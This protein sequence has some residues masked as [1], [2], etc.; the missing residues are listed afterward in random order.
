[1]FNNIFTY[2]NIS[3]FFEYFIFWYALTIMSFY[4]ILAIFSILAISN[5]LKRGKSVNFEHILRSSLAPKIAVI[6]PAFNESATIVENIR[7]LL[8]L[9]Y[10]NYDI[11]IVNDGSKDDCLEKMIAAYDLVESKV[12][13]KSKLKHAPIRAI[14]KSTNKA[15]HNLVVIDK[16]NG[17]KADSLNAGINYTNAKYV[18]NIDVDCIIEDDAL[19]RMIEP[20]LQSIDKKVI[21]AG[22]VVRIANNCEI[23]NGRILN[24]RLPK[25]LLPLYQTLEY[26]RAFLLGR[27]AWSRL[28]G[29][30]II[31][32]AFGLFDKKILIE[33]GGYNPKTVGE[34]M[35]LVV[36]MRKLMHQKKEKYSVTYV[37]DPLCWTEV[38]ASAKVLDR[39][40]N[41]WTRGTIET[42]RMHKDMFM[43]PK[44]GI[45]GMLSYPFWLFYE[46][47]APII[48]FLG[49]VY[50]L[51]LVCLGW[52]NWPHFLLLLGMVYSFAVL[53]SWF[54]I[55]IEEITYREY[56]GYKSLF[57]LLGVAILEPLFFH[58][59]GV[60]AAVKGNWDKF[61]RKKSAW[62]TQTR[63][64][65]NAPIS[66]DKP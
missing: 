32:G 6:A 5:H 66:K 8:S 39:Q 49:L 2:E 34:D 57:T 63:V 37:P 56:K 26:L 47:L 62:G 48:E 27:M 59:I 53:L 58:P 24:V 36:R 55:L 9:K 3:S 35:E 33:A 13:A 22:G 42:L 46:W 54:T 11:I 15:F 4:F 14:Y 21:A 52:V 19:L 61:V 16:E 45:L 17:G 51:V 43:N 10:N 29:L 64:G 23:S 20:F 30:L 40:R 7:S 1:M 18:A 31:S 12:K 41:R 60:W 38:P 25:T 44:Y 50:F 65:F 28:N